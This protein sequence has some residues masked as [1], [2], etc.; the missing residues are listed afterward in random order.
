MA[1]RSSLLPTARS[2]ATSAIK[3]RPAQAT[4]QKPPPPPATASSSKLPSP[5][6]SSKTSPSDVPQ[7]YQKPRPPRPLRK[8]NTPYPDRKQ[9]LFALYNHILDTSQLV[10][11]FEHDNCPVKLIDSIRARLSKLPIPESPLLFKPNGEPQ[12]KVISERAKWQVIRTGVFGAVV[13]R[14]KM[15]PTD[16]GPWLDGQ[17]AIITCPVFSPGTVDA[18]LKAVKASV[19][20][21]QKE[22]TKGRK[23]KQPKVNLIVGILE[24]K[25]LMPSSQ[26]EDVAKIPEMGTARS[27]VVGMLESGGMQL[28]GLLSQAGGGG[29]LRTL[30]GLEKDLGGEKEDQ[31]AA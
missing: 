23:P 13:D 28:A 16:L 1:S 8:A 7:A 17:R 29:I 21:Y 18:V 22:E 6:S 24:G 2:F 14:R 20:K 30:Q 3:L 11:L 15:G 4:L 31:P 19:K 27:Q 5:A 26:I 12:K 25:R 10:L 9:F